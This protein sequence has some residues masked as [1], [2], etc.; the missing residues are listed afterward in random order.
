MICVYD[1][2]SQYD[3]VDYYVE[4]LNRTDTVYDLV[5][6]GS[7]EFIIENINDGP[8]RN[9]QMGNAYR[10]YRGVEFLFNKRFSN[11]WQL[12]LSYIYSQTK[13]T[14]DNTWG[15][16]IGSGGRNS[17]QRGGPNFRITAAR[18]SRRSPPH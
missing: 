10:K 5:S 13:G 9:P 14:I 12:M 8:Y 11:R 18:N 1:I 7:H 3:P 4:P 15:D 6:G 17:Q 16:D 2:L